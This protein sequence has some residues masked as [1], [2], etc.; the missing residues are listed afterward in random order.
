MSHNQRNYQD[1]YDDGNSDINWYDRKKYQNDDD[2][3]EGVLDGWREKTRRE[4]DAREE[5]QQKLQEKY[6]N[7]ID[8]SSDNVA[9]SYSSA[10]ANVN[11]DLSCGMYFVAIL[12]G[13]ASVF[14]TAPLWSRLFG[15]PYKMAPFVIFFS[16]IIIFLRLAKNKGG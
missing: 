8:Y 14:F 5:Q 2:Y 1:G 16:T 13:A 7:A 9:S 6:S 15:L 12:L 3:Y 10:N 11:N 4:E